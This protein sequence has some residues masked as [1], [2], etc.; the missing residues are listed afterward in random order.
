MLYWQKQLKKYVCLWCFTR[1]KNHK[2]GMTWG[3]KWGQHLNFRVSYHF[4]NTRT[5]T[6]DQSLQFIYCSIALIFLF[7]VIVCSFNWPN[8]VN[9][10]SCRFFFNHC[11]VM[12]SRASRVIE[13]GFLSFCMRHFFSFFVLL[14]LL[15]SASRRISGIAI[16]PWGTIRT[17]RGRRV[18]TFFRSSDCNKDSYNCTAVERVL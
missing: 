9:N 1:E 13:K 18:G 16:A 10:L 2:F 4:K 7:N 5:F 12:L 11:I 6:E 3:C 17:H 8:S 15:A 14:L